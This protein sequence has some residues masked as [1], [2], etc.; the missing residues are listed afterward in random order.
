MGFNDSDKA[1]VGTRGPSW[2]VLVC[3]PVTDQE[4]LSA[5][6]LVAVVVDGT[7]DAREALDALGILDRV[8][9]LRSDGRA[10]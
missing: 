6:L 5:A 3:K 7:A 9:T 8:R 10:A 4:A 1:P 2:D